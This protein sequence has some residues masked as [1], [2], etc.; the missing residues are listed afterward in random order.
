MLLSAL[1]AQA[2]NWL[3]LQGTERPNATHK[4]W[5]F[6]QAGY[7]KDYGD[8]IS[9]GPNSGKRSAQSSVA[10]WFTSD[11][12]WHVRRA[13]F[14]VRGRFTGAF[15]TPF[16]A[17]MNYF[18]LFEV[19]PNLLTYDPF[20]TKARVI[21][22]DHA[23]L[24]FNHVKGARVR[25]GLFK[26]PG[27]E[28]TFTAIHTLNYIEFT[29]FVA[30]EQLER[31]ATGGG[32]P[33]GSSASP[34]LGTPVTSAYG[35]NGVRDWG[36]QVFDTFRNGRWSY[37]YA[38]MLGRGEAISRPDD[39]DNNLDVY[40]YAAAEYGLPGGRGPFKNGI[41]M[42]G[43]YQKGKRQFISDT[44]NQEFDR[45]RYGFGVTALGR[46]FG[47]KYKHRINVEAMFADGMLFFAPA[48]GVK[49]GALQYAAESGN[50]SRA[51][52]IDYGFYLNR[53]WEIDFRVARHDLLYERN[54]NINPGNERQ[55]KEWT[56][57]IQYRPTRRTRLTL[58][59]THRNASVPNAYTATG[60]FSAPQAAGTTNVARNVVNTLDNRV[61]LQLT[62]IF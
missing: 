17:K 34:S 7:T 10:P 14:G 16:T 29:D 60:G 37:S 5:G 22:L 20:G 19:A 13:R 8:P 58:N 59:Y 36:V 44:S 2:A 49:G 26:T 41:K 21:A 40:L 57:G 52:S 42:F 30:R 50:K 23:S 56:L 27:P 11:S 15:R 1:P 38:V 25:V 6:I 62:W 47:G 53:K 24:T 54:A 12:R 28:E 46:L 61:A 51:F 48:G 32:K 55:F 43:W 18:T 33:L 3:M 4:F 45:K 39:S 35:L 9:L 31:F